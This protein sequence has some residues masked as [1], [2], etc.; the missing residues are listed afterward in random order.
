M[1]SSLLNTAQIHW[2]VSHRRQYLATVIS[3]ARLFIC[4]APSPTKATTLRCGW[5]NLAAMA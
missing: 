2:G 1:R 5:A 4:I 3:S